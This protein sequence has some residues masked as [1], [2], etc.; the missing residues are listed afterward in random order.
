MEDRIIPHEI[1]NDSFYRA[2]VEIAGRPDIRTILEIGS[3]SGEGST[4]ALVSAIRGRSDRDNVKLFCMEISKARFEALSGHYAK[5]SFVHCYNLS[6]VPSSSFPT[7]DEVAHFHNDV[8]YRF[9]KNKAAK[10]LDMALQFMQADLDYLS[11]NGNDQHGIREIRQTNGIDTFDFVLI[12][13]SEFTGERE[14]C[15]VMGAKIIALDDIMTFKCWNAHRM[16]EANSRYRLLKKS[17]RTR[18]GYSI[19][20][21][22]Y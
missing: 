21:R 15:E 16:L 6:S 4:Q 3:S 7:R 22:Q 18:N 13:G 20:E 12:D 19:F 14:L 2:L 17:R 8:R 11:R 5:D 1:L 9:K 10:K